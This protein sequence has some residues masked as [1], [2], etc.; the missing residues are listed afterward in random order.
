MYETNH[1][2]INESSKTNVR[3]KESCKNHTQNEMNHVYK[4]F[5]LFV[6]Q[7]TCEK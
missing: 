1:M 4:Q 6:I 3:I 5:H 2:D 7:V